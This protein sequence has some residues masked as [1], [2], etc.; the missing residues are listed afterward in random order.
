M[1]TI[2]RVALVGLL[3]STG[4]LG[5]TQMVPGT[6]EKVVFLD[7]GQGDAIL[8]Q[9]DMM[10]VLIDGGPGN[11]VLE[12][13][14]EELPWNDRYLDV[15]INTHPDKDHLEGLLHVLERYD[16]GLVV[17]PRVQHT[18]QL[19]E[20]W[21]AQLV[22]LLYERGVNYQFADVGQEIQM[23]DLVLT[24]LAPLDG[25]ETLGG[26][27]NNASVI[28]RVDFHELSLL[29]TGDAESSAERQLV[30]RYSR[31]AGLLDVD[32]LKA[33][34]HGSKTSTSA[35]LL[36]ASS[37]AAVVISVGAD[38]SYGHPHPT[39]LQRLEGFRV[40]R[41]DQEGSVRFIRQAG[42]WLMQSQEN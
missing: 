23:E 14:A 4:I 30:E 2:G 12:P 18:S 27:T 3:L 8:L 5:L 29:L 33:G 1:G 39:V 15:L 24:V 10:Q 31:V 7:V 28:T 19:Y 35:A 37:P 40:W 34:H 21:L 11:A 20:A 17:L 32:V 13:L 9:D 16:V 26:A 6:A 42:Q 38:N 41:T 25:G 36:E 22:T